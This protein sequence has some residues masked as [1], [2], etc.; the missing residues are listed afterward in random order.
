MNPV[1]PTVPLARVATLIPQDSIVTIDGTGFSFPVVVLFSSDPGS[2]AMEPLAGGTSE[3]DPGAGAGRRVLRPGRFMVVNRPTYYQSASVYTTIGKK[4]TVTSV[5]QSGTTVTVN[6]EGFSP[7]T[8]INLFNRQGNA[9]VNLGGLTSVGQAKIPLTLVSSQK[10]TFK[11]PANAQTG[12]A[13]VMA[14][15][16]PF[17]GFASSGSSPGGSFVL[18]A[19]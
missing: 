5:T 17:F 4:I 8:V 12:S 15:N 16:P 6:G 2:T 10:M 14:I 19:Q 1:D 13:F 9:M 3:P 7:L 11:V 18:T